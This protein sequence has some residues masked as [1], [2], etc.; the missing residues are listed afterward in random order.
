MPLLSA[1]VKGRPDLRGG[2][3]RTL[4]LVEDVGG[5]TEGR[6]PVD[7]VGEGDRAELPC[8]LC[9]AGSLCVAGYEAIDEERQLVI[10]QARW[11]N[12]VELSLTSFVPCRHSS[13]GGGGGGGATS[14]V[15]TRKPIRRGGRRGRGRG[16]F[17]AGSKQAR[18]FWIR[19]HSGR[20]S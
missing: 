9:E 8:P 7:F 14:I 4:E 10:R 15:S 6:P 20:S 3:G 5:G 11:E 1:S 17:I 12:L 13:W 19:K 2:G 18:A 16:S